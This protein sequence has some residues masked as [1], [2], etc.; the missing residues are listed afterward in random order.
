MFFFSKNEKIL[1]FHKV[2][3]DCHGCMI[4]SAKKSKEDNVSC[5]IGPLCKMDQIHR[6]LQTRKT[7]Q[8]RIFFHLDIKKS[9]HG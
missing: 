2:F 7:L 5:K 6:P 1:D 8:G 3:L 9:Q 4:G